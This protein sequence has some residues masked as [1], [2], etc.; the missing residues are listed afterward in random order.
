[1]NG[2][3]GVNLISVKGE[4]YYTPPPPKKGGIL[5]DFIIMR[6]ECMEM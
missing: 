2:H 4:G 3:S 6:F 5:N 1:M